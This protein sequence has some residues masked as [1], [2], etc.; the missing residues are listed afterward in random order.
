MFNHAEPKFPEVQA[1]V[2]ETTLNKLEKEGWEL[3]NMNE[4]FLILKRELP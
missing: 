1:E 2:I 3:Q 4:S